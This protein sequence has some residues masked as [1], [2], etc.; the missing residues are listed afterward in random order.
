MN[1]D[2]A[3][4]WI[5]NNNFIKKLLLIGMMGLTF[6]RAYVGYTKP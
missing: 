1:L 5:F 3:Q 2:Q 4:I 6:T